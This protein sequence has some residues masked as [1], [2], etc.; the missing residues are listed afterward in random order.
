M[1]APVGLLHE[2]SPTG[3]TGISDW[4]DGEGRLE[5]LCSTPLR[6]GAHCLRKNYSASP[7]LITPSSD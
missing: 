6:F 3:R 5:S 1:V 4:W 7:I 2:L